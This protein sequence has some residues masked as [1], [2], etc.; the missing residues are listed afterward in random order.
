MTKEEAKVLGEAPA[1]LNFYGVSKKGWNL[2]FT[3]RD[4]DEFALLERFAEFTKH[5]EEKGVTPKQVGQQPK[6]QP[7]TADN[8]APAPQQAQQD[9]EWFNCD[10]SCG[11]DLVYEKGELKYGNCEP[12][13]GTKYPVRVWPEV[14]KTVAH[15]EQEGGWIPLGG[16]RAAFVKNEKGYPNKIVAIEE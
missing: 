14:I 1:S 7:A 2:Q 15:L 8:S 12:V 16:C 3:L 9:A 11:I 4:A 10:A 5:L 13:P 6:T